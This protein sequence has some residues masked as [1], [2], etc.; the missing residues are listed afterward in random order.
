MVQKVEDG[1]VAV[2]MIDGESSGCHGDD[3]YSDD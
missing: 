3:D 1:G 2:P